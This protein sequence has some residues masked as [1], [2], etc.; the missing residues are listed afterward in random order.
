MQLVRDS[1]LHLWLELAEPITNDGA[2]GEV[3]HLAAK[4]ALQ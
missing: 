3:A 2:C 1:A 4:S